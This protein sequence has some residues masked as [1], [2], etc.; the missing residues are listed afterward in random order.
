MPDQGDSLHYHRRGEPKV[1]PLNE[2]GPALPILWL[3][4][5][6]IGCNLGSACGLL[7]WGGGRLAPHDSSSAGNLA[8]CCPIDLSG[9][10]ILH[11]DR[12]PHF[13]YLIRLEE[14]AGLADVFRRAGLPAKPADFSE[15]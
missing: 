13:Y 9:R 14:D 1:A 4:P 5:T 6:L 10:G 11:L 8:A 3:V 7:D 15:M 2:K 12:C